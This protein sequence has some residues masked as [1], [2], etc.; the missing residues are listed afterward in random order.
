MRLTCI[1]LAALSICC[2]L[3]SPVAA[4]VSI[5]S[6]DTDALVW[7]FPA[8][9][10]QAGSTSV[11]GAAVTASQ[12]PFFSTTTSNFNSAGLLAT[13]NQRRPGDVYDEA[14]G[15]V[16]VSFT[17]DADVAY[18]L[19]GSFS[20]SFGMTFFTSYLY[21]YTNGQY[22]FSDAQQNRGA[23]TTVLG[24]PEG[25]FPSAP[26]G[27]LTGTLLAGHEYRWWAFASTRWFQEDGGA[28]ASGY[29]SLTFGDA[30]QEEPGAVPAPASLVVWL[31]LGLTTTGVAWRRRGAT[32]AR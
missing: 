14:D 20:N 1:S 10:V 12:S 32:V 16:G 8:S 3:A 21:D 18:T 15:D 25:N 4:A 24:G 31:L 23:F 22:L 29:A 26:V 19:G 6:A 28:T 27:S 11:T 2:G 7:D 17:V 5:I 9:P 30:A 13:F